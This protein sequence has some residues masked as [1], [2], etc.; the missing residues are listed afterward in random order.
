MTIKIGRHIDTSNGFVKT[1]YI[2]Y[3]M[4]YNIF[5]I[6]TTSP[7]RI[8][9]NKK[10]SHDLEIFINELEKYHMQMVIH[11]SYM[12]NLCNP[13]HSK[14]YLISINS[15]LHD[16][17]IASVIGDKCLGVIIHMGKNIKENNISR[18]QA[19]MNYVSGIKHALNES[20]ANTTIILETGAS[21]GTEVGSRL[22]ELETIYNLF[23]KQ[24]KSRIK[25][26]IDTCHI[27]ATGYDISQKIG[28]KRFFDEFN[29]RFGIKKI[30][31]IHLNDSKT[32]CESKVDRHAD[33]GYGYIGESGLKCV[34]QL[35]VKYNIPLIME[36]PIDSV[37]LTTN[38]DITLEDEFKCVTRWI[39]NDN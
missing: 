23:D 8:I 39:R 32:I 33:L 19:I 21:Q 7:I 38:R 10:S 25:F 29:S 24:Q 35:A 5:Q 18:N 20:S 34:A 3:L 31:C 6:F 27:W 36:T 17:N 30:A 4:K 14:K 1:P 22:E 2:A 11:G 12:I 13:I 26:C 9:I 16:L 37:N 28:V 15:L